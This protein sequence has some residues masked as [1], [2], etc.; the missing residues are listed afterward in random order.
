MPHRVA[1]VEAELGGLATHFTL[2]HKETASWNPTTI[3]C[4][5]S[6]QAS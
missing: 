2:C 6:Q 5:Q 4:Q 1:D 3:P